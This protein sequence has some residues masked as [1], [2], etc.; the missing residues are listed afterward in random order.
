MWELTREGVIQGAQASHVRGVS[1]IDALRVGGIWHLYVTTRTSPGIT[2]FEVESG[3]VTLDDRQTTSGSGLRPEQSASLTIAGDSYIASMGRNFAAYPL[4][5]LNAKGDI[6]G[7][8][9]FASSGGPAASMVALQPV[10][11]G[12]AD[13]LVAAHHGPAALH[14][15][16]LSVD[17][18]MSRVDSTAL[19]SGVVSALGVATSGGSAYALSATHDGTS[20][21]SHA[22]SAAGFA[23]VS[24]EG[25]G[26]DVGMGNISDIETVRIKGAS[27]AIAA[28]QATSSLSVFKLGAGGVLQATDH[29]LD[30]RATRFQSV[31]EL[32]VA[33]QGD[34]AFVAAAGSDD[35]VTLLELM[36]DGRLVLRAVQADT[37]A[38]TLES[39]G[40]LSLFADGGRLQ[41][42]A[43]S[44]REIGI[45]HLSVGTGAPGDTRV[46]A[47]SHD[48][49]ASGAGDDILLGAEG[50]D[51]LKGN[52]GND[53]LIDGA[54]NDVLRGGAGDDLFVLSHDGGRDTILDFEKGGD[55]LDLS[56]WPMLRRFGQIDVDSTASG[57]V[58][59]F[60]NEILTIRSAGGGS[61][62]AAQ[63]KAA[64]PVALDH[65]LHDA[66]AASAGDTEA[67][68]E[69]QPR[70]VP[71]PRPNIDKDTPIRGGPGNDRL[72]GTRGAE[73]IEGG[74]GNDT[75]LGAGG[76]D[77]LV[78]GAGRDVADYAS[79]TQGLR[80]SLARMTSSSG[81]A[82]GDVLKGIEIVSGS[83]HGDEIT[84]TGSADHLRGAGGNDRLVGLRNGDMLKGGAGRDTLLGG[85]GQDRLDGGGDRDLVKGGGGDDRL[86]GA[87]GSDL[88]RGQG[89]QDTLSG[90]AGR[91][92]LFGD[93]GIDRLSGGG[94]NDRVSGGTGHDVLR[95]GGG[96][97][98]LA[99]GPGNDLLTGNAGADVFV[100][101]GGRDRVQ[102]FR[103]GTDTLEFLP[104]AWGGGRMTANRLVS[105]FA[106]KQG[107]TVAFDFG[108]GDVFK[109][110]FSGPL[111]RLV[112][113]IDL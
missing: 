99:G 67:S 107:D 18:A 35:G 97:D 100:F 76:A 102:D 20:I 6:N 105:K 69:P 60:R 70:P 95:G 15:H 79:S 61:L 91:D 7:S 4:F 24:A 21:R 8:V 10:E 36:P 81:D 85:P 2:V 1:D 77:T 37:N 42:F 111:G 88:L 94:G 90:G 16:A 101:S 113:D 44:G 72:F 23:D 68:S 53:V 40:G 45:T 13:Y 34:R 29:V 80:L 55:R 33:K 82:R 38:T 5:T 50:N 84:G 78:G 51:T 19:D 74:G 52:G 62:S 30:S 32:A 98:T 26:G 103:H 12:G 22:I 9:G 14:L 65:T 27:F 28:G 66:S 87:G 71:A 110:G 112:D 54:G 57:A 93:G 75:L 108:G 58:L 17:G 31:T 106:E 48:D 49:I 96:R 89:G 92:R 56:D 3:S 11:I 64:G 86:S 39:V 109:V 41:I 47:A 25:F 63:L 59:S 83:R 104:A 46:G 43:G 73:R